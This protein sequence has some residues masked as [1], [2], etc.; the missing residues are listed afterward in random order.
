MSVALFQV[1]VVGGFNLCIRYC[2]CFNFGRLLVFV[3]VGGAFILVCDGHFSQADS[4]LHCRIIIRVRVDDLFAGAFCCL[5]HSVQLQ[6]HVHH[7]V[8]SVGLF[9]VLN[10]CLSQRR[11]CVGYALRVSPAV[12]RLTVYRRPQVCEFVKL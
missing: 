1:V 7:G 2:W 11:V 4:H 8:D 3:S 9:F 6:V 5:I 10:H 12:T